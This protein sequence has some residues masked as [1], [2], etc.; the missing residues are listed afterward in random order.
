MAHLHGISVYRPRWT[1]PKGQDAWTA[2]YVQQ[3]VRGRGHNREP[4]DLLI[5][6]GVAIARLRHGTLRGR[7]TRNGYKLQGTAIHSASHRYLR[8]QLDAY[9]LEL[10]LCACDPCGLD[11]DDCLHVGASSI[12][13][14][15]T[16]LDLQETA[17]RGPFGR[18]AVATWFWGCRC[19]PFTAVW[20]FGK[21]IHRCM[22]RGGC[23]DRR[24][25]ARRGAHG[26]APPTPKHDDSETETEGEDELTCQAD[27][28]SY[29]NNG[30]TIPLSEQPCRDLVSGDLVRLMDADATRSNQE[31]LIQEDAAYF[32]AGCNHHR[33]VYE[34]SVHKRR[35][36]VDGCYAEARLNK[37]GLRLCKLHSAKEVQNK[38][39][40]NAE[41]GRRSKAG[42]RS[43]V[44]GVEAPQEER[45]PKVGES[46][47]EEFVQMCPTDMESRL[48]EWVQGGD[49][50]FERD[51]D[52]DR[53]TR[54]YQVPEDLPEEAKQRYVTM[55]A[56]DDSGVGKDLQG[57]LGVYVRNRLLQEK[58]KDPD[59]E[60][61]TA[62]VRQMLEE[63][64]AR[65]PPQVA[66]EADGLLGS[67]AWPKVGSRSSA[68]NLTTFQWKGGVGH[69][70]MHYA[71]S[72][73]PVY[74]YGDRLPIHSS[75]SAL[76]GAK[77]HGSS[78]YEIRQCLLLHSTASQRS[79][80]GQGSTSSTQAGSPLA[81]LS[82]H[83]LLCLGP[84]GGCERNG[85][86]STITRGTI[87]S[88]VLSQLGQTP[89]Y[90]WP[91][92]PLGEPSD[93]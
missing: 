59:V 60:L 64:R 41:E 73:W 77:E 18:C 78:D 38:A 12:I 49:Q 62:L 81:G 7:T 23:G 1:G 31:E 10:H 26:E 37:D 69:A 44:G 82:L 92:L 40:E 68:A 79:S 17:G 9:N 54:T 11:D 52:E 19:A 34:N 87:A 50:S 32:F 16:E 35:C 80:F 76:L 15:T 21:S 88:E 90:D 29:V 30:Q 71:G 27:R 85:H 20:R 39:K 53:E 72:A 61:T 63:A 43:T 14:R 42:S 93:L 48:S 57:Q 58:E 25:R 86:R 89:T 45:D 56:I 51:A 13:P 67:R 74:D 28:V 4:H 8:N 66:A 2:E 47:P 5:T 83:S 3:G 24:E 55:K 91:A 70:T 6:D 36:A 65:G 75:L 22:C 84:P 33:A 46:P